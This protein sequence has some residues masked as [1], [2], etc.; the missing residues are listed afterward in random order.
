MQVKVSL[1]EVEVAAYKT[2]ANNEVFYSIFLKVWIEYRVLPKVH[3]KRHYN[4]FY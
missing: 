4:K 1:V 3:Y 2:G